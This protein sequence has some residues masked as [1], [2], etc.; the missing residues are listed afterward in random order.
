MG[1]QPVPVR[2]TWRWK[3]T[4][5]AMVKKAA[6]HKKTNN[7][8]TKTRKKMTPTTTPTGTERNKPTAL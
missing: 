1:Q 7:R 4:R 2:M 6:K 8:T 3:E 5:A